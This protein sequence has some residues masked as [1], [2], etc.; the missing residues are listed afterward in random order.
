MVKKNKGLSKKHAL[1]AEKLLQ[2]GL[3]H[4][5]SGQLQEAEAI[6]QSILQKQPQHSDAIHLLGVIAHQ[7][8]KN[9]IAVNL[10]DSAIKINPDVANFYNNAGEAYRALHNYD[11]ALARY[12]KAIAIKPDYA[13]AHNNLGITLKDVDRIDEAM[14]HYEQALSI[15]PDYVEAHNN[16]ALALH[17]KDRMDEAMTHYEQALAIK[18]GFAEAHN[19]LGN[20][21]KDLGREDE[22]ID[23]YKHALALKPHYAEAHNNL[24]ISL[25]DIDEMDEANIHFEQALAINPDFAEAHNS[26]GLT[27]YIQDQ[28]DEAITHYEQALVIKPDYVEA[29]NNLGSALDNLGHIDEAIS[30]YEQALSIK[31]DYAMAHNNLGSALQKQGRMDEAIARFQQALMLNPD[32]AEAHNNLGNVLHVQGQVRDAMSHYEQALTIKSDY[33]EAHNNLGNIYSELGRQEDAIE[34]F[35]QSLSLKPDDPEAHSNLLLMHNYQTDIDAIT[36]FKAHQRWAEQH[37]IPLADINNVYTNNPDPEKRLR[38]AYLSPDFR[39]HSVAFFM[40]SI[41]SAHDREAFEIFAY[42]N[43]IRH[44]SMSERLQAITDHWRCIIGMNDEKV[45]EQIREDGIDILVDLAGHTAHN[46]MRVFSLKPSPIQI[47]YLGYPNTSGLATM[48]YRLTDQWADPP[49]QTE[50]YYTEELLRLPHGFLCYQPQADAPEVE[51]LPTVT[52]G[53]ITFGSFNTYP[54]INAGVIQVWGR[55]LQSLPNARL[56]MKA[57]QFKDDTV[58][59]Q[60]RLLFQEQGVNA[61]Q[62]EFVSQIPSYTAHLNLYNRVDIALDTF[63][64]N[65]TT[66]TCE[67]LWMGVPVVTLAG[68]SHRSRVGASILNNIGLDE[69]ITDNVDA[70]VTKVLALAGDVEVLAKLNATIRDKMQHSSLTNAEQFTRSL[71]ETYKEVW[72]KWCAQV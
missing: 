30:H 22:A 55:I 28:M 52:A 72:K 51:A 25:K 3:A 27:F 63:P 20:V 36:V 39:M 23:R 2:Q 46:R 6:Y 26:L 42:H 61:E 34:H 15:K 59:E 33:A 5:Q 65:G 69:L 60:T 24:G 13:E 17:T 44:D 58:C 4:H 31:P 64:Y 45:A 1:R 9:E 70:Y 10:I 12:E 43:S 71:E 62:L 56:L 11:L 47:S 29:H 18:P 57:R 21:F 16:L 66:T 67:A 32:Y 35:E 50:A 53:H 37:A 7:V 14:S 54:K 68:E 41:F 49:G 38:I 40:E 8:G 48:D 19:N